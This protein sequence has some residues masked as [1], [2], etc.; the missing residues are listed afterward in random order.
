MT[1]SIGFVA[2]ETPASPCGGIA[3]VLGRLPGYVAAAS[4]GK[5]VVIAPFHHLLAG[6]QA[7]L[8]KLRKLGEVGVPI[9]QEMEL[10]DVMCAEAEGTSYYLKPRNP[11]F[12]AGQRHPY[13]LPGED[14]LRDSL[15]F[16]AAVA[17]SLRMLG[18]GPWVL[19]LQDWETATVALALAGTKHEHRL[20]LTLHNSYDCPTTDLDILRYSMN[21]AACPGESVLQRCLP[22]VEQKIF[23]VSDQFALDFTE[24]LLQCQVMTP[25]LQPLLAGRLVGVNNGPFIDCA[26]PPEVQTAA[27]AGNLAPL[28]DWK[29]AR[30]TESVQALSSLT[31]AADRPVWG[32]VSAFLKNDAPWLVMAGRDDSRQKGYDVAAAA[33]DR[34]LTQGGNAG[35]LFFPIPGDE[36]FPGLTFLKQLAEK[37]P[38]SVLILPFR[39]REGFFPVLQAAAFGIMPSLYEPFG[40]ANEFYL[41]GTS[42]IGRATGGIIQQIAPWRGGASFSSAVEHRANRWHSTSTHPTGILYREPDDLSTAAADWQ[43]LNTAAYDP[44]GGSPNRVT[45]RLAYPLFNHMISELALALSDSLRLY[46]DHP[47][48]YLRMISE[49]VSYIQRTFSWQR[50]AQQYLRHMRP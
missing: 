20:F 7:L 31:S 11:Q 48:L 43:A 42:A 37:H 22:L 16:G 3:A 38:Q 49:G 45:E 28:G 2:Y 40:M 14:L 47:P 17:R 8:P 6:C 19:A 4:G 15:F 27:T 1:A 50:T 24:D 33:I 29:K 5:A 10:V 13:D 41:N 25:H 32:N 12:F 44:T 21:A 36:G 9:G 18:S 26:I 35:F 30:R 34:F 39:F 23:T 46:R